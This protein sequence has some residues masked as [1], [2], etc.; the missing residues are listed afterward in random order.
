[1]RSKSCKRIGRW[2]RPGSEHARVEGKAC[3][4]GGGVRAEREDLL[5]G[6]VR[7]VGGLFSEGSEPQLSGHG[8]LE[9]SARPSLS[10][11]QTCG[12][13]LCRWRREA[14]PEKEGLLGE[15]GD[16]EGE[17]GKYSSRDQ[18]P[19]PTSHCARDKTRARRSSHAHARQTPRS[20][21]LCSLRGRES[22]PS[23]ALP[24][25]RSSAC[26]QRSSEPSQEVKPAGGTTFFLRCLP[27]RRRPVLS[28]PPP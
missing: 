11:P 25:T 22:R 10:P 3:D 13:L 18:P 15:G 12:L 9:T 2:P 8:A 27:S 4:D 26:S 19:L 14:E 21:P 23:F 28:H 24:R 1:M 16:E 6:S 5:F 20:P 17:G 7:G